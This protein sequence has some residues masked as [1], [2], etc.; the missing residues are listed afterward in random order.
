MF[1]DKL[2]VLY[3]RHILPW[4]DMCLS[5]ASFFAHIA[6]VFVVITFVLERGFDV[7]EAMMGNINWLYISCWWI[8]FIDRGCHLL[9]KRREY[10]KA[11]YGFVGKLINMLLL[12]MLVPFICRWYGI[13]L[14]ANKMMFIIERFSTWIL[15]AVSLLDCFDFITRGLGK[16]TNPSL[17]LALSFLCFILL[18]SALLLMPACL[19]QGSHVT[20]V[21]TLFTAT[22]AVCVTGL[23]TV[24]ITTEFTQT[25]H[26]FIILLVQLGGLGIMTITSF[27]AL[28]FMG[29]ISL[30]SQ[31]VV[32]DMVSSQ[33]LSG[34][35]PLLKNI[36]IF[37]F[38]I[39]FVGAVFI[40]LSVRNT[41]TFDSLYDMVFF[42][43]FH[44]I[45][46]FCN[47]GFSTL[48]D[49][50]SNVGAMHTLSLYWVLGFIIIL[51]SI[52]YPILI[53][54]RKI[55][56]GHLQKLWRMLHGRHYV[57]QSIPHL[58]DLNTIIVL[59]ATVI[60][61]VVGTL[62]FYGMECNASMQGMTPIAKFTHS[63]F[64]AVCPRTA[65]FESV[66]LNALA[67]Q[68]LMLYCFFMWVGGASQSTAGGIKLNTFVT[69]LLN[70]VAII[71]GNESVEVSNRQL[72][73]D[74]VRR[75][76]A[77]ILAS[78]L[79]IGISIF[80]MEWLEPQ[81]SIKQVSF[82]CISAL[83]TVGSSL[84][85]T[86]NLHLGGKTLIMVLMFVGRVGMITLM[87]GMIANHIR[88]HYVLPEE[89]IIIS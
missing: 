68:S 49:G 65:G 21:D 85:V 55:I 5:V 37:T 31:M 1:K 47:A 70:L 34:L 74:S 77:T 63:F 78:L 18:G 30:Y 41:L 19:A 48:P 35:R 24:D 52:G 23:S 25:G 13:D 6:S 36:I 53:N 40:F 32:R 10:W 43:V 81:L 89:N 51:G 16:R 59:K 7:S 45:S 61:V 42:C 57:S 84:G 26:F 62:F 72:P 11:N 60:F 71:K 67:P 73:R 27:F 15:F 79:V 75:A 56:Y 80:L 8:Y 64:T 2:N 46:A 4:Q 87:Q 29:N 17:I 3:R 54:F 86:S 76:N 20:W 9:C 14:S 22:S 38:V 33:S 50:L 83:G 12:I 66:D 44:S 69:S 28:F 58:F 39:E 88:K 82:E